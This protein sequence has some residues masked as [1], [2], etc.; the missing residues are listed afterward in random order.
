MACTPSPL[1]KRTFGATLVDEN[2]YRYTCKYKRSRTEDYC[3]KCQ[4]QRTFGCL[5][6]VFTAENVADSNILSR[7]NEHNGQCTGRS[8]GITSPT[9]TTSQCDSLSVTS[10]R[11]VSSQ[12]V[13]KSTQCAIPFQDGATQTE[14][15]S[16]SNAVVECDIKVR[17][18]CCR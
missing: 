7:Q 4:N 11:C 3:W 10:P 1:G 2:G 15:V 6:A 14:S 18:I 17:F 12:N 16:V 13:A 5:A 9:T 8:L